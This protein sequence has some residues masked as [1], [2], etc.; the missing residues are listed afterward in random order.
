MTWHIRTASR[1]HQGVTVARQAD[2]E[3]ERLVATVHD[4]CRGWHAPHVDLAAR[5]ETLRELFDLLDCD[6]EVWRAA[7][8]ARFFRTPA[9]PP[10]PV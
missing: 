6:S 2:L 5:T 10:C 8:C 4:A 7:G 1:N 3:L 9:G